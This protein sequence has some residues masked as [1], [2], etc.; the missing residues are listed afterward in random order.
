MQDLLLILAVVFGALPILATALWLYVRIAPVISYKFAVLEQ[1]INDTVRYSVAYVRGASSTARSYVRTQ[2]DHRQRIQQILSSTGAGQ[3]TT[4]HAQIIN[5]AHA[6][7][8][9]RNLLFLY[10]RKVADCI[11]I[12]NFRASVEAQVRPGAHMMSL[13]HE[14]MLIAKRQEVADVSDACIEHLTSSG[15][16]DPAHAKNLIGLQVL[17]ERCGPHECHL[18]NHEAA[19]VPQR[20]AAAI[21]AGVK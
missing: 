8:Q 18:F 5:E 10:K 1:Q 7:L 15:L 12:H 14:G 9:A 2:S 19:T 17:A 6:Q 3:V 21:F 4:N 20:C 13:L 16:T 11:Q